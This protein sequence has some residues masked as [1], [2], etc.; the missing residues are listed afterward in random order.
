MKRFLLFAVW[1]LGSSYFY[2]CAQQGDK[3][4]ATVETAPVATENLPPV[5]PEE[6]EVVAKDAVAGYEE[7]VDNPLNDWYFRVQLFETPQTFKFRMRLQ[8]EEIRGED[9]LKIPN[10][11]VAPRVEIRKGPTA[12]SCIIG[13]LDKQGV[14]KEY[15]KV[16]VLNG[17][18]KVT[19]L[20]QYG[21][22]RVRKEVP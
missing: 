10:L 17:A 2:S 14:F 4:V 13:F 3:P 15:K 22:S 16:Y 11:G 1:G 8:Y 20:H 7:K 9:T 21:V 12:Y 18:L 6:R 5:V 19:T